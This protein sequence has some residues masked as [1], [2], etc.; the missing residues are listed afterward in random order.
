M[1]KRKKSILDNFSFNFFFLFMTTLPPLTTFLLTFIQKLRHQL[2]SQTTAVSMFSFWRQKFS[3]FFYSE[4]K[5]IV[6]HRYSVRYRAVHVLNIAINFCF[7]IRF[8]TILLATRSS[9]LASFES[10][11]IFVRIFSLERRNGAGER[12]LSM[13]F[14]FIGLAISSAL[15]EM[16]LYFSRIDTLT[17]QMFYDLVVRNLDIYHQCL[18]T[19]PKRRQIFADRVRAIRGHAGS[20]SGYSPVW[21][22]YNR[23][24]ASTAIWYNL[25]F[26]DKEKLDKLKLTSYPEMTLQLRTR[27]IFALKI[28][29]RISCSCIITLCKNRV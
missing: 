3:Q 8:G 19:A 4:V 15:L 25:D 27:L 17:W 9:T 20:T 14:T 12:D 13:V 6:E 11:D 1:I 2:Q 29:N 21:N 23:F 18:K 16:K 10:H 5:D 24:Q 22:V 28:A 26:V 7:I